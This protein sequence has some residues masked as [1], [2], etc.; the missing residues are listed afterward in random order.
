M[1]ENIITFP[2]F[3]D[4]HEDTCVISTCFF[5][6][7]CSLSPGLPCGPD[8]LGGASGAG[9]LKKGKRPVRFCG[10]PGHTCNLL[11]LQHF[12]EPGTTPLGAVYAAGR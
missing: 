12:E 10:P 11:Y 9:F 5:P 4:L 2:H 6:T 8:P 7:S 1:V 3:S